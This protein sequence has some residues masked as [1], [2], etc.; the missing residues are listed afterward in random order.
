MDFD[1]VMKLLGGPAA[2]ARFLGIKD[3]S[4]HGWRSLGIPA[5]RL[6][7]LAPEIERVSNG[8]YMRWDVCPDVW[9]VRWPELVKHPDAPVAYQAAK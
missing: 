2:V 1:T 3:P 4:V 9:H 5:Y 7:Q 8:K 6:E